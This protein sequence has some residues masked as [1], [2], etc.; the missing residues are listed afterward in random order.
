MLDSSAFLSP[1]AFLNRAESVYIDHLR[2]AT[3]ELVNPDLFPASAAVICWK[4]L[5]LLDFADAGLSLVTAQMGR[6]TSA[7]T[8]WSIGWVAGACWL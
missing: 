4:F 7:L 3:E 6:S 2:I 5:H 8:Y 1:V